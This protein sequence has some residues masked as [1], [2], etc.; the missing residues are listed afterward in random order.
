MHV[1]G[2]PTID[3]AIAVLKART[4]EPVIG[5]VKCPLLVVHG[6]NDRQVALAHAEKTVAGAVNSADAKLRVFSV[7][8]GSTE[9]CGVDVMEM[10]GHYVYDWAARILGGRVA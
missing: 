8:E 9:H 7:A 1:T 3:E 6:E 2:K 4:L 5:Q 10:Q